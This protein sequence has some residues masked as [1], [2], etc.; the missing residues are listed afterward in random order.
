[1]G[2]LYQADQPQL[3][4]ME[5]ELGRLLS[6]RIFQQAPRSRMF[7]N[8]V[9]RLAIRNPLERPKEYTIAVEVFG[10]D[11]TYDSSVDATV[12]VEAGRL[13]TRLHDYYANEGRED[14]WII[15]MPKGAY[16]ATFQ[17]RTAQPA[18]QPLEVVPPQAP[19]HP[20][21]PDLRKLNSAW[22]LGLV[23]AALVLLA[24]TGWLVWKTQK[25][26][27]SRADAQPTEIIIDSFANLTS[28][29]D[30]DATARLV[31]QDVERLLSAVPRVAVIHRASDPADHS[32]QAQPAGPK[33]TRQVRLTGTL[34]RDADDRLAVSLQLANTTD[35]VI[36]LDREY[37]LELP[38]T[39][40]TQAE[41]FNDIVRVLRIDPEGSSA[42]LPEQR[43]ISPAS[44]QD[45]KLATSLREKENPEDLRTSIQLLE[46][47][48]ARDP[49]FARAWAGLA[50]SHTLMGLY[51]EPPRDHMPQARTAAE[52]A[53]ALDSSL[54][55][56]HGSLGVVHLFYDWDYPAAHAEVV[57][58][59]AEAHAIHQL[60]CFSH[61]L[62]RTGSERRA[63]EEILRLLAYD[64]RSSTLIS[65]L[66]CIAYYRGQ[67]NDAVVHYREALKGDPR[68]AVATWGL[69]KSLGQMGRYQEALQ[70]L[71]GYSRTSGFE[72]PLITTE[73]AYLEGLSGHVAE[74]RAIIAKLQQA[75]QTSFVDP[76]FIALIYHSL[77]DE[78]HSYLYLQK[79]FNIRSPF[80]V[81]LSTEPKW[82]N[83]AGDERFAILLHQLHQNDI[84]AS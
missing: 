1:M 3:F 69:G 67:Y 26:R 68:S 16:R 30:K 13:R 29:P 19:I 79:A 75:S 50:E 73:I 83:A 43:P 53:I 22:K 14:P 25:T 7:L 23:A 82:L 9:V 38:D 80:L 32:P 56:A 52:R 41:I 55:G 74:A 60:A 71:R 10:C 8:Y 37:L 84:P 17:P 48:V 11:P 49:Q 31:T 78:E 28:E 5:A 44:L 63:E 15:D 81:S 45:F 24:V 21:T 66:G 6:S 62:E 40:S 72:P 39:R 34:R 65:E 4:E 58:A 46:K 51:F 42:A 33:R 18:A 20:P 61:L 36:V 59:E 54:Q 35:S 77:H 76:Y 47:V 2:E 64:P 12:R 27:S 57:N 70:V